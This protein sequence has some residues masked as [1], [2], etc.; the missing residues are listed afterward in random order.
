MCHR[1]D[2]DRAVHLLQ[3]MLFPAVHALRAQQLGPAT[4]TFPL[5]RLAISMA[6]SPYLPSVLTGLDKLWTTAVHAHVYKVALTP[7]ILPSDT[8]RV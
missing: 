5:P 3:I 2:V 4:L 7:P 1:V 6:G 8:G